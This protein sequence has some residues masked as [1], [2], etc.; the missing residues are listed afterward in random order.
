L[1]HEHTKS[2]RET[3]TAAVLRRY[4][5]AMLAVQL[6]EHHLAH[7]WL[8][9]QGGADAEVTER[10]IR[11]F[12]RRAI[13][14]SHR[15]SASELRRG[16]EGALDEQLLVEIGDA[17]AAR[18]YLAHQFLRER[19]RSHPEPHFVAGSSEVLED[20]RLAFTGL[21]ITLEALMDLYAQSAAGDL[22]S[23]SEDMKAGLARA[24]WRI[25][26]GDYADDPPRPRPPAA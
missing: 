19:L 7:V 6:F 4:G 21:A 20:M 8:W 11:R 15:A 17:I 26:R 2:Q 14:V 9:H 3:D 24:G 23:L 13:H 12:L 16:L 1:T 18:N 10:N 25:W 5:S 22:D